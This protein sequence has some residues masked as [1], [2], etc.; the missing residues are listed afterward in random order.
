M[1]RLL[2]LLIIGLYSINISGQLPTTDL[3][4]LRLSN[5]GERISLANPIYISGMNPDGYNNQPTFET[6]TTLFITSDLYDHTFTDLIKLDLLNHK[7][8]RITMTDSISEYSPTPHAP[9]HTFSTIRVE[10]DGT[11]QSLHL[12]PND[13]SN[14]GD[15]ML[16]DIDNI[17]YHCWLSESKVALILVTEPTSLVLA[18]ITNGRTMKI[19]D[20]VGRCLKLDASANIIFVHKVRPDLWYLKSYN[21]TTSEIVTIIQTLPD[22][23]DFELLKDG[24]IIMAS[25]SS[26]YSIRPTKNEAWTEVTDLY[27]YGIN[28]I[29]RIAVSRNKLILVNKK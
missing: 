17:G 6:P 24:T 1:I 23:E 16:K 25:G 7:Y 20:N 15:R 26:I 3:Y 18:D 14:D 8:Y 28:N 27:D 10:K 4:Q 21:P 5:N 11:T 9:G 12:Y 22:Q 2:V 13:H 29:T 19:S